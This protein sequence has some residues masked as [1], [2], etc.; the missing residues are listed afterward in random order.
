MPISGLFLAVCAF[1]AAGARLEVGLGDRYDQVVA[2][3]RVVVYKQ[4]ERDGLRFKYAALWLTPGWTKWVTKDL[5]KKIAAD[6]H[7]P[8]LLYYTFGD[9]SS[10]EY[11]EAADRARLRLWQEDIEKNLAPLADIGSEVLIALEPEFNVTPATGTPLLRWPEWDALAGKAVDVIHARAP[12]AKV[13]LCPGD[14][15]NYD[16]APALAGSIAKSDF[17]AFPEMRAASDPSRDAKSPEYRDAAGAAVAFS[18]YLKKTFGK[19][20]LFAYLTVSSHGGWDDV[21][22]RIIDGVFAREKELLA[23]GVFGLAYFAYFDDRAHDTEFFG[24]AERHFGLKDSDGKPKKA[25]RVW[26]KR[27]SP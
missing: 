3:K 9:H 18:A 20:I 27:T 6:G 21:Q 22:A 8:L 19:P 14:W 1:A 24:E 15:G 10:R 26:K 7:T 17:I 13:G 23:N 16:L 25:W 12:L 5:L 2:G 4:A 11:L